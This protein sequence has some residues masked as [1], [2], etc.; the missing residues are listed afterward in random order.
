MSKLDGAPET[1][2]ELFTQL[3]QVKRLFELTDQLSVLM[4]V[5]AIPIELTLRVTALKMK[6]LFATAPASPGG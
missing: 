5:N 1:C 6:A 2:G 3:F 4:V